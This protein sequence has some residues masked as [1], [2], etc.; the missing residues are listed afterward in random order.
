MDEQQRELRE[1]IASQLGTGLMKAVERALLTVPA[2]EPGARYET[3][4]ELIRCALFEVFGVGEMH[5]SVA[6]A[7]L[8]LRV[9]LVARLTRRSDDDIDVDEVVDEFPIQAALPR[10]PWEMIGQWRNRHHWDDRV[11]SQMGL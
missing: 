8:D 2:D 9:E 11:L 6:A 4:I 10:V 3:A 5:S 1:E 7:G